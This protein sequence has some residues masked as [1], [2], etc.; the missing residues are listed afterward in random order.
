MVTK[1]HSERKMVKVT[2]R[3]DNTVADGT[4]DPATGEMGFYKAGTEI[5]VE[6][7]T[8]DSLKAKRLI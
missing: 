1:A 2:V 8:A 6:Q 7:D 3:D 5:E 4:C